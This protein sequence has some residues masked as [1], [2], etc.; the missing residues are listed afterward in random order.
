MNETIRRAINSCSS[1]DDLKNFESNARERG[2]FDDEVAAAVAAR[3]SQL[4]RGLVAKYTGLDLSNLNAAEEKI[5]E[6]VSAYVAIKKAKGSHAEYTFRQ[7]RNRGFLG[8][9]ESAVSRATPTAGFQTLVDEDLGEISYERIVLDH[10]EFFTERAAWYARRALGLPNSTARPPVTEA[11]NAFEPTDEAEPADAA[12]LGLSKTRNPPWSRDE[13]I[14]AL[15]LYVRHGATPLQ[16]GAPEIVEL[17][18]V[19]NCL[20]AALDQRASTT[21]RNEAGVYMKLMNFRSVDPAYAQ[22]GKTG[23]SR[24]NKDEAVVWGM[25]FHDPEKLH[26]VANLIRAGVQ[27][28]EHNQELGGLDEPDIVEAEEGRVLTRLHRYRER[29]RR[30]VVAAK[31]AFLKTHKRLFCQCC[32]LDFSKRYGEAGEGIIDVHHAKPVHTLQPGQITSIA[33]LILLCA[34]CHRVVHSKRKWLTLEEVQA[35]H[36]GGSI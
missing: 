9:A 13:L 7:I 16:K 25:Y 17:S 18:E 35:A 23:L 2:R 14:L 8:A 12:A 29:D 28:H 10:P 33:D 1:W 21:Y 34:N 30:L 22:E 31:Q 27:E 15:D 26:A 24:N 32:G 3:S 20:G 4:G 5:V 36:A 6:A 19:L 11:A